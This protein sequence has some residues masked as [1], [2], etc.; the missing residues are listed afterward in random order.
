M[1]RVEA[2]LSASRNK[3]EISSTVGKDENSNGS[4]MK[5]A[6][7]RISTEVMIEKASSRSSSQAGIG[8]TRTTM[9]IITP[10]PSAISPRFSVS[11]T[12]AQLNGRRDPDDRPLLV[13]LTSVMRHASLAVA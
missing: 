1:R 11:T 8:K 6:V 4:R 2:R 7:I 3:V 13:T 12:S 5:S 9:I 10:T